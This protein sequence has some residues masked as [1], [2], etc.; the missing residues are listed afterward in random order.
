[1]FSGRG[2]LKLLPPFWLVVFFCLV[3]PAWAVNNEPLDQRIFWTILVCG[4]F[5]LV[6]TTT[7]LGWFFEGYPLY[8]RLS[9]SAIFL[10][11]TLLSI[12]A[13]YGKNGIAGQLGTAVTYIGAS[14]FPV[15]AP[16]ATDLRPLL[17]PDQLFR[18]QTIMSS[19][20]LAGLV[21]VGAY[22]LF[23]GLTWKD[24]IETF[25]I[26]FTIPY[27]LGAFLVFAFLFVFSSSVFLHLGSSENIS[28][29]L[30][31]VL[32]V[33]FIERIVMREILT[34]LCFT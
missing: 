31:G 10:F 7:G 8:L 19:F 23:V 24:K 21:G 4:A 14:L 34:W 3:L 33:V 18:A 22:V 30:G 1:M 12:A 15:V 17:P 27:V 29:G 5:F 11:A 13:T 6:L 26:K 25:S 9:W 28:L 16:Y 32:F 20:L 2:F